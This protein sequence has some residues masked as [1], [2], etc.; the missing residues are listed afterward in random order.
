MLHIRRNHALEHATVHLLKERFPHLSLIGRS[1]PWGFYIFGNISTEVLEGVVS[2]ALT[3][4]KAGERSLA[5]HPNCGTNLVTAGFLAATTSFFSLMGSREER[6]RER[7]ERLPM[8]VVL[9]MLA[10]IVAQP[11]GNT[12]QEYLTTDPDPGMMEVT[13][14]RLITRGQANFHRVLT[15][16]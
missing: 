13:S 11:L 4:L 5:I 15:T 9:T 16:H 1:D 7:L 3:R 2:E 6:W 10:L 8:A 14:V 12:F